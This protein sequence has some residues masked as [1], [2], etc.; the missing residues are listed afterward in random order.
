MARNHV[1]DG[2][3]EK[4]E[5]ERFSNLPR[6]VKVHSAC[7]PNSVLGEFLLHVVPYPT[8]Y[9]TSDSHCNEEHEI[10]HVVQMNLLCVCM[11]VCVCV[12]ARVCVHV[13]TQ[14][15]AG[16]IVELVEKNATKKKFQPITAQRNIYATK[17]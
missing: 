4:T 14:A 8:Q 2:C 1:H 15:R 17:E 10:K 12:R 6:F 3:V 9:P 13:R 11:C 16:E 5:H 7:A